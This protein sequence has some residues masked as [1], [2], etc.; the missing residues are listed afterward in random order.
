[1]G[2]SSAAWDAL[3]GF[4]RADVPRG[5]NTTRDVKKWE[6]EDYVAE[7][8]FELGSGK[9][10]STAREERANRLWS[11]DWARAKASRGEDP[12]ITNEEWVAHHL[13]RDSDP[14]W[15][16]YMKL[17]EE[18]EKRD[19]EAEAKAKADADAK[20]KADSDRASFSRSGGGGYDNNRGGGRDYDRP[21]L[22]SAGN[23]ADYSRPRTPSRANDSL[24]YDSGGSIGAPPA[25]RR[26]Q[27]EA[28][29]ARDERRATTTAS[30]QGR[31]Y[32]T[33][34]NRTAPTRAEAAE[35]RVERDEGRV[36]RP[37]PAM[38]K[39][40]AGLS[41]AQKK[42]W[43][44]KQA[45]LAKSNAAR[46]VASRPAPR[47]PPAAPTQPNRRYADEG[48]VSRSENRP[49]PAPT[50]RVN[51]PQGGGLTPRQEAALREKEEKLARIQEQQNTRSRTES[52]APSRPT[53]R[54]TTATDPKD[55][56][57]TPGSTPFDDQ[58]QAFM[59]LMG[60][61]SPNTNT[62][63]FNVPEPPAPRGKDPVGIGKA[64]KPWD[65]VDDTPI[66]GTILNPLTEEVSQAGNRARDA[67][68][69]FQDFT[70]RTGQQTADRYA[71]QNEG[72]PWYQREFVAPTR[73]V[74][75]EVYADEIAQRRA[76]VDEQ[77]KNGLNQ[78]SPMGQPNNPFFSDPELLD[79]MS[80]PLSGIAAAGAS[81]PASV[82]ARDP[83]LLTPRGGAHNAMGNALDPRQRALFDARVAAGENPRDVSREMYGPADFISEMI[84]D[85]LN[86]VGVGLLD[87]AADIK[88]IPGAFRQGADTVKDIAQTAGRGGRTLW[89]RVMNWGSRPGRAPV[90]DA[91]SV[92]DDIPTPTAPTSP[93]TPRG[94]GLGS[95]FDSPDALLD[96]I[97]GGTRPDAAGALD[98]LFGANARPRID[99]FR[100]R[101][102]APS[103]TGA[104]LPSLGDGSVDEAL[105]AFMDRMRP[106]PDTSPGGSLPSLGG[107]AD[108]GGVLDELFGPNAR[109]RID[110]FLR[111]G[112]P[113]GTGSNLPSLGQDVPNPRAVLDELF[114]AK[115]PTPNSVNPPRVIFDQA[116]A[117]SPY[118]NTP[119]VDLNNPGVLEDMYITQ[120]GEQAYNRLLARW[121]RQFSGGMTPQ[122]RAFVLQD[123]LGLRQ[124]ALAQRAESVP[125]QLRDR[126]TA[127]VNRINEGSEDPADFDQL[128]AAM[129]DVEDAS[130]GFWRV[131]FKY[132]ET[133]DV[134]TP[135][136]SPRGSRPVSGQVTYTN[137][138]TGVRSPVEVVGEGNKPGMVRVRLPGAP[139]GSDTFVRA[140]TLRG[141]QP[142][143]P[144]PAPIPDVPRDPRTTRGGMPPTPPRAPAPAPSVAPEPPFQIPD[145]PRDN[146][147]MRLPQTPEEAMG[148]TAPAELTPPTAPGGRRYTPEEA[149]DMEGFFPEPGAGSAP[150]PVAAEAAPR[151]TP[152]APTTTT[153]DV[154]L[155]A[156]ADDAPP[157]GEAA[158]RA[159]RGYIPRIM[160]VVT[161][162]FRATIGFAGKVL[163]PTAKVG[164][165]TAGAATGAGIIAALQTPGGRELLTYGQD[166]TGEYVQGELANV[167]ND[168]VVEWIDKN[169]G[170]LAEEGDEDAIQITRQRSLNEMAGDVILSISNLFVRPAQA[171]QRL[172]PIALLGLG[173][174]LGLKESEDGRWLSAMLADK[175]LSTEEVK[176]LYMALGNSYSGTVRDTYETLIALDDDATREEMDAV[177]QA[178]KDWGT[179]FLGEAVMDPLWVVGAFTG[180]K[181]NRIWNRWSE[182]TGQKLTAPQRITNFLRG[183]FIDDALHLIDRSVDVARLPSSKKERD[184]RV[185]AQQ[186]EARLVGD[187]FDERVQSLAD[188]LLS[189]RAAA[190]TGQESALIQSL[191]VRRLIKAIQGKARMNTLATG[192]Q[193]TPEDAGRISTLIVRDLLSP[194]LNL[195]HGSEGPIANALR[196]AGTA[197]KGILSPMLLTFS[198]RYHIRNWVNNYA[199]ALV[200]G[201]FNMDSPSQ[202]S[203][204]W[205]VHGGG[206]LPSFFGEGF[207]VLGSASTNMNNPEVVAAMRIQQSAYLDWWARTW[208]TVTQNPIQNAVRNAGI[209]NGRDL[210]DLRIALSDIHDPRLLKTTYE[211]W[212]TDAV[213]RNG[214]GA[215]QELALR[216]QFDDVVLPLFEANR[217]GAFAAAGV[218]RDFT[219]LNYTDRTYFDNVLD[220]LSPYQF[221]TTRSAM[222]W[223]QRMVENPTVWGMYSRM[224]AA[225][226]DGMNG[227]LT[228]E[229]TDE[230]LLES[231]R[232]TL[233]SS[234]NPY[235]GPWVASM[236][237]AMLTFNPGID[238]MTS[239]LDPKRDKLDATPVFVDIMSTFMPIEAIYESMTDWGY[240][241]RFDEDEDERIKA[242]INGLNVLPGTSPLVD[243]ALTLIDKAFFGGEQRLTQYH[244]PTFPLS[245]ASL[246][247][248]A[249]RRVTG[250]MGLKPQDL[251]AWY[252]GALQYEGDKPEWYDKDTVQ[253]IAW[254]V[255]QGEL[256]DDEALQ[257]LIA[258]TGAEYE[259]AR[260]YIS[261]AREATANASFIT[262]QSLS[263]RRQA[264]MKKVKKE[265]NEARDN[266]MEA[267]GLSE[268]DEW[269]NEMF[270]FFGDYIDANPELRVLFHDNDNRFTRVTEMQIDIINRASRQIRESLGIPMK[271]A[272]LEAMTPEEVKAIYEKLIP[273]RGSYEADNALR[274]AEDAAFEEDNNR[275]A[276]YAASVG[277]SLEDL[278]ALSDEYIRQKETLGEDRKWEGFTDAEKQLLYGYW[279]FD[280]SDSGGPNYKP[281]NVAAAEAVGYDIAYI[282]EVQNRYFNEKDRGGN[283]RD[284]VTAEEYGMLQDYWD[285]KR[286][287]PIGTSRA[288]GGGSGYKP[289]NVAAAQ[290]IGQ[291]INYIYDLQSQ[292]AENKEA[293]RDQWTGLD[294]AEKQVLFDYW[295]AKR[296]EYSPGS[297][298]NSGNGYNRDGNPGS[299]TQ[300]TTGADVTPD[301]V[302]NA[303]NLLN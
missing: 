270:D 218:A 223:A 138:T 43:A 7:H 194:V 47:T 17:A 187:T 103:P 156:L 111:E 264:D 193:M 30:A 49:A 44:A 177:I 228:T 95:L 201:Y 217:A 57:P 212:V 115:A 75:D 86:Y 2:N 200:D 36:T 5:V 120:N 195:R 298:A 81:I 40:P 166:E 157:V 146:R 129:K 188:F 58:T 82:V 275:K 55:T 18:E 101:N 295:D 167:I 292:W 172:A 68:Q 13:Q 216:A 72:L 74:F 219:I 241:P 143:A 203:R 234:A 149:L 135:A 50:R 225:F 260:E 27:P 46:E 35:A 189:P 272:E 52:E 25:A 268:G 38:P 12:T 14:S 61:G 80:S 214:M 299:V 124:Q 76:Q 8:G 64:P 141:Y 221:W 24:E 37:A 209:T 192:R 69:K 251:D 105:A 131:D 159:R 134:L 231:G 19:A 269:N 33:S 262:G 152:E 93:T 178:N 83:D 252:R 15:S 65:F 118:N 161:A 127:M 288:R 126:V 255:S 267:A 114:A 301:D 294:Y 151:V 215:A 247:N 142:P 256:S 186:V 119:N 28:V 238:G 237:D 3:M 274:D 277:W 184:L 144:S 34:A 283:G 254:M 130:G 60:Q 102:P 4:S 1:M 122:D 139:E 109:T 91:A 45:K 183:G 31:F 41:P 235:M 23:K 222:T 263:F 210:G 128:V 197:Q 257:Q 71:E 11:E 9:N 230:H 196:A 79:L 290:E 77:F 106:A 289:E 107:D 32:D 56:R 179:D 174:G 281:E 163:T 62:P 173:N 171:T 100:P 199:T 273:A 282:Y 284:V 278:Q 249:L 226:R 21:T 145:V 66:I 239:V 140:E 133:A 266:A 211:Q 125:A 170:R 233:P 182:V 63:N 78:F 232:P 137:P 6:D 248:P 242:I 244:E 297:N 123:E 136:F 280:T 285:V 150:S 113:T 51:E 220:L 16:V 276:D 147:T 246:V 117:D 213:A 67:W 26:P 90:A 29:V 112:K 240:K 205:E 261:Q 153:V 54:P 94:E 204:W 243:G 87:D 291:D 236:M 148:F 22:G 88:N 293:G 300:P 250:E 265:F 287:D 259:E 279:G 132:D 92:V 70:N 108:V 229:D 296:G 175:D 169:T 10:G 155:P 208:A 99:P 286:G 97:R 185:I 116:Y 154:E 180:I 84:F 158:P 202:I 181:N 168:Q 73:E 303:W 98:D 190:M 245:G 42:A 20:A 224:E 59:D 176:A 198:P 207:N 302:N 227:H 89:D 206:A 162:P 39:P 258:E 271:K 104:N 85:P 164:G 160:E 53:P 48:T 191:D 253:Q 96:A 110:P 165:A 121:N